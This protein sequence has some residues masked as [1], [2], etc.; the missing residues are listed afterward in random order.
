M[1]TPAGWWEHLTPLTRQRLAEEPS[2]PVPPN[3][4]AELSAAGRGAWPTAAWESEPLG[5]PC[6]LTDD[7]QQ[8]IKDNF[9]PLDDDVLTFEGRSYPR[10][11]LARTATVSSATATSKALQSCTPLALRQ[12]MGCP[13]GRSDLFESG[14]FV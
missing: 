14:P 4:W 8:W 12:S 10:S 3:L 9:G 2:H 13:V 5:G 6:Y 7:I 11:R 1:T